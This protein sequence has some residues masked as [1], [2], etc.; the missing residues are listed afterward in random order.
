MKKRL[1]GLETEYAIRYSSEFTERLDN[2]ILYDL[3]IK[4]IPNFVKIAE[5]TSILKW[6]QIFIENGSAFCYESL[7]HHLESGLLESATP[8]CESPLELL[9]Y[10]RAIDKLLKKC[11]EKLNNKQNYPESKISL[12]K[13][14]KDAFDNIYGAQENYSGYIAKGITLFLYRFFLISYL[15]LLG[16]YIFFVFFISF[17]ILF[18]QSILLIFFY[19][20]YLL[21]I[22]IS[23]EN[24][25]KYNTY[26][27]LFFSPHKSLFYYFEKL[28]GNLLTFTEIILSLPM[29]VP[30]VMVLKYLTFRNYKKHLLSFIITRILYTGS[31]SL[32][33]D[34]K[35]YLSE[36]A[37]FTKRI[38]RTTNFPA[39][40]CIF[41]P[42]NQMKLAYLSVISFLKFEFHYLK[43]LF[44]KVQ[45]FQIGMSDS[46]MAE[47]AELLKVGP[48][49]LLMEMIDENY[50][51]NS[52][53]IV[54]PIIFLRKINV[55]PGYQNTYAT[56]K[57][58][59]D[60][61]LPKKMTALEIQYWYLNQTKEYL[62]QKKIVQPEYQMIV[63]E[64]ENVLKEL[65]NEPENLFG[66][67]DW[68][69]K[70]ILINQALLR[71]LKI[72]SNNK[73]LDIKE[74]DEEDYKN[75]YELLK[76]ID[77]KY[78]DIYEGYYYE[79]EKAN[80]T[81]RFFTNE[82]IEFAIKN[83]PKSSHGFAQIRSKIIRNM[84][85]FDSIKISWDYVKIGNG[86]ISKIVDLR[87]Y[88][89]KKD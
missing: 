83:P 1:I 82:E 34:G 32:G 63:Q 15:P 7:P 71:E 45:R 22:A 84:N 18:F 23:K 81:K 48:I 75:Y 5:G 13:N 56:I 85:H 20:F 65:Q 86:A 76:I 46:C 88:K 25:N 38:S 44:S 54:H 62:K 24:K 42:G 59:R 53:Q 30:Y 50:L 17:L 89:K 19:F 14:C 2:R 49:F 57:N 68:I 6:K 9:L 61:Q 67:V 21:F 11:L 10:Q 43:Q 35:Y 78:H 36:K 64:W 37:I 58:Y 80:L 40:R 47:V 8:E 16:F 12:I 3:I 69:T 27:V 55:Y 73:I 77:I 66:K 72:H 79:L 74:I 29:V 31:G 70:R 39:D 28:S 26:D 4:I 33:N 87:D 51:K 52:P 41:D 60:L